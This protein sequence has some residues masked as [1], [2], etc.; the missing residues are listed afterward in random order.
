M[1]SA[2]A[3]G[4]TQAVLGNLSN[5]TDNAPGN[6]VRGSD[7]ER[8][9]FVEILKQIYLYN[10]PIL[11]VTGMLGNALAFLVFASKAFRHTSC[12]WYL[13]ARAVSDGGFLLATFL[14]WASDASKRGYFHTDV[15]CQ[16]LVFF[17]YLFGFLSV[18]LTVVVTV[19]NYI[20]ICKPFTVHK[21]CQVALAKRVILGLTLAGLLLYNYPLWTSKVFVE[22]GY[23][24]NITH[25]WCRADG[26]FA[27][28]LRWRAAEVGDAPE[29]N[30]MTTSQ[31][32]RATRWCSANDL[33]R[34][35]VN[36]G[37]LQ[38]TFARRRHPDDDDDVSNKL[39]IAN[40]LIMYYSSFAVNLV[41]Y[42]IFGDNFRKK[43]WGVFLSCCHIPG[44]RASLTSK[45]CAGCCGN[46]HTKST[47]QLEMV[48]QRGEEMAKLVVPPSPSTVCVLASSDSSNA[49]RQFQVKVGYSLSD[50]FKNGPGVLQG[51]FL[52]P[53]LFGIQIN[54]ITETLKNNV[55]CSLYAD[56]IDFYYRAFSIP[57]MERQL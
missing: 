11:C 30:G 20:R 1:A 5:S 28:I 33:R 36:G 52:T 50:S 8:T 4:D 26:G 16:L 23:S 55:N 57:T 48:D 10:L 14:M 54:S 47:V 2:A 51:S 27:E 22:R 18:W 31:N 34:T 53:I 25:V 35:D 42:L 19:E 13:A 7:P 46:G 49:N 21:Y 39:Y 3:L 44:L 17:P 12:S 56:D 29:R 45:G 32:G 40:Y 37:P 6:E 38:P 24:N 15:L 41:I 9:I 43:V